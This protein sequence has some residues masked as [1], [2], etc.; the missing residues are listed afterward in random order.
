MTLRWEGRRT[1]T[2][3]ADADPAAITGQEAATVLTSLT[4]FLGRLPPRPDPGLRSYPGRVYPRFYLRPVVARRLRR[5]R[6]RVLAAWTPSAIQPR[7]LSDQIRS[8]MIRVPFPTPSARPSRLI[9]A[10]GFPIH[11][12]EGRHRW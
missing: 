8:L 9:R 12:K 5:P 3:T 7:L 11:N 1:L 10:V 4:A 6:G 2:V